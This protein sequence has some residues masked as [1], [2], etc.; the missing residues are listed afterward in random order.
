VFLSR[1]FA[2]T[3]ALV[4]VVLAAYGGGVLTGVM[5]SGSSSDGAR[6]AAPSPSPGVL[7][8]AANT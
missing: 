5:G 4:A 3:A 7:E 8:Q 1:R 2:R 6:D